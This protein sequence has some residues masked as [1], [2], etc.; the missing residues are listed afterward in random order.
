MILSDQQALNISF[1]ASFELSMIIVSQ[2]NKPVGPV[3]PVPP[4]AP[5]EPV[6]PVL[7]VSQDKDE[8]MLHGKLWPQE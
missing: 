2:Q 8:V 5:L 1:P 6:K 4:V 3:W 7:P